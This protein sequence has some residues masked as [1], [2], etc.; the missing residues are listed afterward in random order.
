MIRVTDKP[1]CPSEVQE[2]LKTDASG[3]VVTHSGIVR[4]ASDEGRDVAC[5]EY[6]ADS[7]AAEEEL[8]RIAGDI[9]ARW[10]V[11]DVALCRRMGRLRPGDVILVTAVSAAH[12]REAFEACQYAVERLKAM[13]SVVK[14][15]I[16]QESG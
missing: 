12:R 16:C 13:K 15:E 5:I 14:R 9:T 2:S 4:A 8:S 7:R 3:S 10:R 6:E 1:L 11:Q